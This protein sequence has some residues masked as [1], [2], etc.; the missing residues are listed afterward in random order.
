MQEPSVIQHPEVTP[1]LQR[2][3][4]IIRPKYTIIAQ[5]SSRLE[6]L[7]ALDH[8]WEKDYGVTLPEPT[9]RF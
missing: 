8:L 9:K 1:T 6:V 2:V 3:F 5:K 4:D 7:N